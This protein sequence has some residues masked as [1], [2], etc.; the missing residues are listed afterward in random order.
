MTAE[1]ALPKRASELRYVMVSL[2]LMSLA[3]TDALAGKS[4]ISALGLAK[5][6]Q[7]PGLLFACGGNINIIILQ[8]MLSATHS[9]PIDE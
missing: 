2:W 5:I 9:V 1:G 6:D 8:H 4:T 7:F 3:L